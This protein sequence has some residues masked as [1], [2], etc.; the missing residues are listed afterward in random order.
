MKHTIIKLS[1]DVRTV[2]GVI[3]DS[4]LIISNHF[5]RRR[6]LNR[7][8]A[9]LTDPHFLEVADRVGEFEAHNPGHYVTS[10][11]VTQ[12]RTRLEERDRA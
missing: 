2:C 8:L 5:E 9:N 11:G 1:R 12:L 10:A 4:P 3:K 6:I 7:Q